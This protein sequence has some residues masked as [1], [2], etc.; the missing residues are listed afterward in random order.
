MLREIRAKHHKSGE[1]KKA[2][3]N[4]ALPWRAL[5]LDH[6]TVV[7]VYP[8]SETKHCPGGHIGS[9]EAVCADCSSKEER[10]DN[11]SQLNCAGSFLRVASSP[12]HTNF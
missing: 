12:T 10:F 4:E 8:K 3:R 1:F 9:G 11:E 7:G 6:D 5:R 2:V